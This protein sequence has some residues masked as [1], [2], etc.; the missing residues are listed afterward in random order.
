MGRILLV[1]AAVLAVTVG[2]APGQRRAEAGPRVEPVAPGGGASERA[3]ERARLREELKELVKRPPLAG[4]RVG[5]H[6]VS[7]DTG[8]VVFA[9]EE[10]ELLNPASNVK[11]VTSAAVL[12]RLGPEFRFTTEF[13]C[14]PAL[15]KGSCETLYVKGKGDPS[16]HTERLYGIAGELLHRG[17]RQV[18]NIVVDDTYFDEQ[19]DGPGWDQERTD[20][21]YLAPAGAL[22]VNQNAVAI[23]VSAG[24]SE[25][26]K[27]RVELEPASDF[28][29]IENEVVTARRKSRR[30]VTLVSLPD[31][32][33][34]RIVVSG[35]LPV[36][37]ET[38]VFYKKIHNPPM[39]A[40]ETLKAVLKERG[41][42]V[43]GPVSAGAVP[44]GAAA[45]FTS[46]S[47]PLAEIV[48]E[49]NKFSSNFIAE[50]LLKTLGAELRGA[51]GSWAKGVDAVEEYLAE[52]GIPRGSY[53]MKNGSGLNDVN[54]FSAAQMTAVLA[55][56]YDKSGYF[57]EYAASLGVAARDGTVRSRLEGTAAAGRLRAKTGT[58]ENV[59]ALS[60]YVRLASGESY[61]YSILVNDFA[62]R[63]GP[64]ISLVDAL[65]ATIAAGGRPGSE[66]FPP[67]AVASEIGPGELRARVSTY[68]NLGQLAD[69]RNL[70]F[71]RSV[72]RTETDPVLRAVV[73]DALYRSEPE[74]GAQVLL[75]NTPAS[76]RVFAR[77][78][79]LAQELS[80]AT[81]LVSSLIE[82]GAEGNADALDRLL[83]LAAQTRDDPATSALLADGF[84][85]IGRTAPDELYQALRRAADGGSAA[86]ELLGK[87][88]AASEERAAHPFLERMRTLE[89]A[90][91]GLGATSVHER[92]RRALVEPGKP[93]AA[94]TAAEAPPASSTNE[95][96]GGG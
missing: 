78:R 67:A 94:A 9:A 96:A 39:Y 57:P 17:V 10:R 81:P 6:V 66:S 85:D 7:L 32:R 71:L 68:S 75:E 42:A 28:F 77:L 53:V 36:G 73:A 31:G 86:L 12:A 8:E 27:A 18:K 29:K 56:V 91:G 59:T 34:Q 24:E 92:L 14:A 89:P 25:R 4:A 83:A 48:R 82:V 93:G 5:V 62:T 63:H 55:A 40:G 3:L 90:G 44:P 20:K 19:R 51:P 15:A 26:A 46:Y 76:P 58:L 22:S 30:R 13:S 74:S 1:G 65:A 33:Q 49:L 64:A 23:Y 95:R 70:Q 21:P 61:A 11:L 60:G 50:Q 87:G 80:M 47:R 41:I 69:A 37:R 72:L 2:V 45:M 88:I 54:R 84:Q 35:R 16:L 43:K 79:L 38:S 52:L